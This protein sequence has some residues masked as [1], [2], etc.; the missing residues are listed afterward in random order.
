[1]NG[2][3]DLG[4]VCEV[5]D[6]GR[7]W[8]DWL[9]RTVALVQAWELVHDR[10]AENNLIRGLFIIIAEILATLVNGLLTELIDNFLN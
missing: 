8:H 10:A 1:M 5:A 9:V 4:L 7:M 2:T 6:P 3:E